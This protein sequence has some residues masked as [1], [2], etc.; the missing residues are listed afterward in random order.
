MF[1]CRV[2]MFVETE[3]KGRLQPLKVDQDVLRLKENE[4]VVVEIK[5]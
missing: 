4:V 1:V 2:G 3:E 5:D